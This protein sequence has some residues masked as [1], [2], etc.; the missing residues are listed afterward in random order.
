[1]PAVL[2]LGENKINI[3]IVGDGSFGMTSNIPTFI[4]ARIGDIIY[5]NDMDTFSYGEIV[6]VIE[7]SSKKEKVIYIKSNFS[8]KSADGLYLKI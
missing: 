5:L 7:D 2:R 6:S 3:T 4:N 8:N 1:M